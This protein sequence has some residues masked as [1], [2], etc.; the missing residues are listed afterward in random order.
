MGHIGMPK[1]EKKKP[2]RR[3]IDRVITTLLSFIAAWSLAALCSGCSD[4]DSIPAKESIR[5]FV[6]DS[7]T[8]GCVEQ[9]DHLLN[10]SVVSTDDNTLKAEYKAGFVYGHLLR[11]QIIFARDYA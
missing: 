10:L 2:L 8:S 5:V 11:N 6:L 1:L 7:N 9:L 4:S 3:N